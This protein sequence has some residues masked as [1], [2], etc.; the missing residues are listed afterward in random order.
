M[1]AIWKEFLKSGKRNW[2]HETLVCGSQ[3][4][5]C[6]ETETLSKI[7]VSNR[8]Q[9]GIVRVLSH[10]GTYYLE[11]HK[12]LGWN[13]GKNNYGVTVE[14]PRIVENTN[15]KWKWPRGKIE[16]SWGKNG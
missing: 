14:L 13:T 6:N 11:G 2:C 15:D 5:G 4:K 1:S 16:E 7:N 12:P 8:K 10:A 9:K 3:W